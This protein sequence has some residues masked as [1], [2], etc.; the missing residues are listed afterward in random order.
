MKER[1]MAGGGCDHASIHRP[2]LRFR[3]MLVPQ[4]ML[5]PNASPIRTLRDV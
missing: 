5:Q 2:P 3:N 1:R 4:G